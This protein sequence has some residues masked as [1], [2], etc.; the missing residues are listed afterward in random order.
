VSTLAIILI[1]IGAVVILAILFGM[2]SRGRS[3]RQL[4]QTQREA[5]RDD[6]AHHRER[7]EES[8]TEAAVANERAEKARLQAELDE[9]R[10]SQR[11]RELER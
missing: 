2:L 1:V 10:A 11:E 4:G 3:R 7:A 8:R 6:A 5:Q 9:E